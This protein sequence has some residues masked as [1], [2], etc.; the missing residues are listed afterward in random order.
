MEAS[1]SRYLGRAVWRYNL[2]DADR[3]TRAVEICVNQSDERPEVARHRHGVLV[4]RTVDRLSSRCKRLLILERLPEASGV[5]D[6]RSFLR[7]MSAGFEDD[8]Y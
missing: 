5:F 4:G 1:R 6:R 8:H 2:V 3:G 7:S